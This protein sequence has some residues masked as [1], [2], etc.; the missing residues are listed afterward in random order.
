VTQGSGDYGI[1]ILARR[2][3][4][5]YAIQCKRW[6]ASVGVKAVQE[7]GLGADYYHCDAAA[8]ITNSTYTKQAVNLAEKTGV[9]LWGREFLEELIENYDEEYDSLDPR[10]AQARD[11]AQLRRT[12]VTEESYAESESPISSDKVVK[13]YSDIYAKNDKI[14]FCNH[15]YTYKEA[16]ASRVCL[17]CLAWFIILLSIFIIIVEPMPIVTAIGLAAGI[18]SLILCLQLKKALQ[19]YVI[20]K[21]KGLL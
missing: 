18:Y 20:L 7:A 15:D 13:L 21:E 3:N 6:Q 8:V 2:K 19:R 9:R 14:H 11:L 12:V 16:K 4:V 1:D 10:I 5:T 17:L